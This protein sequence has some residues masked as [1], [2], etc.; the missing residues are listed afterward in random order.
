MYYTYILKSIK[1]PGAIYI[2]YTA[3]L[4]SRVAQHNSGKSKYTSK[5]SPWEVESYLAFSTKTE[6]ESF[7]K[8]LKSSSGKSFMKKHLISMQFRE[9]LAEFNNARKV[10]R[11]N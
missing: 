2:G 11:S 8:Y 7:E 4:K 9:A 10:K 5:Y 6:A 1:Q 3:D